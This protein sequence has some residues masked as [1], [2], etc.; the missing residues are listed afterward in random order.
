M[1]ITLTVWRPLTTIISSSKYTAVPISSRRLQSKPALFPTS[2]TVSGSVAASPTSID[3]ASLEHLDYR[4]SVVTLESIDMASLPQTPNDTDISTGRLRGKSVSFADTADSHFSSVKARYTPIVSSTANIGYGVVHLYRETAET[5]GLFSPGTTDRPEPDTQTSPE[6]A[7]GDHYS[8]KGTELDKVS[9]DD[10]HDSTV[11]A[12]LAVPAYMTPSDFLGYVGDDTREAFRRL[13]DAKRFTREYNGR[14]FNTMEPETCHVVF[15]KSVQFQLSDIDSSKGHLPGASSTLVD[16]LVQKVHPTQYETDPP[17][18]FQ[19]TPATIPVTAA[20]LTTKP[21]PPPT[22]SLLEL[23]TC[24]VCLERMDETTGLLTTQC[25]HVFHCACLSKWKDGSC[26]VCRYTSND[27]KNIGGRPKQKMKRFRDGKEESTDED[28]CDICFSCGAVDNLWI[29]LICG[30]VGCGRYEE[31]HAFQHYE[32]TQHCFAMDVD[33]QRVWDYASDAYVHRLVQNK[34][35]GKLV[36]LPSGRNESNTDELYDKLDN[37]GM[38][39]THLLTR[40]LDSQRTYFEEQVVAAADKA[41]KASRRAD[42]ASEK[43]QEALAALED[44][45]LKVDHLSQ[46][47]VPSLERSKTRAEKKAEKATELLRKF[48]KDWR[49]EKTVNDGLL[50]RVD[51]INKEREELLRENADLKDQLRDMMFFVE[52]REKLKEMDEEGIEEGEVTIGDAPDGKKKRK[53]KGKG[54]R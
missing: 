25:Q 31:K 11:V 53:G 9:T 34:A 50:E 14:V 12:I 22:A 26:P 24:P 23:P 48:E 2:R 3:P 43:L 4:F 49:E 16:G 18:P 39:Y 44:L 38:E 52:G 40:Q 27:K 5:P 42:E 37:I 13:E 41:T 17:S 46:D 35:D 33:T 29:C 51:K 54:K 32:Q 19:Q 7:R 8:T 36:E 45:K 47:I 20:H 21:A 28:E 1:L 10:E 15:V 6:L 30:H